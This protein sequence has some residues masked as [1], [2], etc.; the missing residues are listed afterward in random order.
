M[1]E[2]VTIPASAIEF[3]V[4]GNTIWVHDKVGGT[5]MRIKTLGKI[6][7]TNCRDS[8]LSHMD[9]VVKQDIAFC[10]AKNAERS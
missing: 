4:G 7:A 10:L 5:A 9:M 1:G 2:R 6:S 3:E 8:P